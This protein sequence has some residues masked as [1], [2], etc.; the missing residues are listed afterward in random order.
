MSLP[1]VDIR[2]KVS[3]EVAAWLEV[4]HQTTGFD[5][6]EIARETL[7]GIAVKKIHAS[8][9]LHAE[10]KN[11]GILRDYEVTSGQGGA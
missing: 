8:M 3:P 4:E 6:S 2:I 10:L 5:K 9:L 11:K 1:L 7:H